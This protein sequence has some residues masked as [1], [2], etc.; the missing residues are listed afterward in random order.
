[1]YREIGLKIKLLGKCIAVFHRIIIKNEVKAE[2][3]LSFSEETGSEILND[4][5]SCWLRAE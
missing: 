3:Q 5:T 1:M 4:L 2:S